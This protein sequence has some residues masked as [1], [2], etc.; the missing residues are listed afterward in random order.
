MTCAFDDTL[1]VD[2]QERE[3]LGLISWGN[4]KVACPEAITMREER[5]GWSD[6]EASDVGCFSLHERS[7]DG[8]VICNHQD[9]ANQ[10]SQMGHVF[11]STEMF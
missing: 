8:F 4:K 1:S 6:K 3:E 7:G 9:A 10:A 11:V 5:K 2:E